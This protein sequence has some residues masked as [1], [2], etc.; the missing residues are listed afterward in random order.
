MATGRNPDGKLRTRLT[1]TAVALVSLALLAACEPTHFRDDFE[2]PDAPELGTVEG[3]TWENWSSHWTVSGNQ[4]RPGI[5][6]A[7]SV[8]PTDVAEGKL[9]VTAA[10]I[11]SEFW[12]VLRAVDSGNYWRFGRWQ[13]G[14]Y[15]LQQ[16]TGG[17]IGTPAVTTMA[18][19]MP[20]NGDRLACTYQYQHIA[21]SV[22]GQLV[23]GT[24]VASPAATGVGIASFDPGGTGSLRFDGFR[25]T[26]L[27]NIIDVQAT[28]TGPG[29][30]PTGGPIDWTVEVTNTGTIDRAEVGLSIDLPPGLVAPVVTPSQGSCSGYPVT[31]DLGPIAALGSATVAV[32]GTAPGSP[33][34]LSVTATAT[35]V[36]DGVPDNDSA[37]LTTI[38]MAPASIGDEVADQFN[39]VGA[40]LGQTD[41]GLEWTVAAGQFSTD[42]SRAVAAGPGTSWASVSTPMLFGTLDVT[43]AETGSGRFWALF[44]VVDSQNHYR[45]GPGPTG[46]YELQ[47]VVN[48]VAQPVTHYYVR[49]NVAAASGDQIRIV[50][51]PDD[52]ILVLVNDQHVID[53]GDLAFMTAFGYG[54]AGDPGA[55]F[56]S[57]RVRALLTAG[58]VATDSFNRADGGPGQLD[59]ALSY[60]WWYGWGFGILDQ[61][62]APNS[63]Y[64]GIAAVDTA[65]EL[66]NAKVRVDVKGQTTALVFRYVEDG[67]HYSFGQLVP[68]GPYSVSYSKPGHPSFTPPVTG[69]SSPVPADGDVI[70]VRQHLDGR[71]E[72]LVNGVPV[73]EFHDTAN[74]LRA[75]MYGVAA[76][77]ADAR[78]DDFEVTPH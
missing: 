68:D 35:T 28:M 60:P 63:P 1:R 14:P 67:S 61:K 59:G 32:S 5:G 23:A 11:S 8:V 37:S 10:T 52:S 44:G 3:G 16:V 39:R 7:L 13:G 40:D 69:L 38:V 6:Y 20:A 46:Y 75:T 66:A 25:L 22:S 78:F 33:A 30:V 9:Y 47:K 34:D 43:V 27:P 45:V 55:S 17:G 73:L 4:A 36:E 56:D 51:R 18:H 74:N 24:E 26:E 72:G 77:G 41:D 76:V 21:C 48:G 54:I 53:A 12:L 42:G 31:C 15:Q 64:Y 71:V 49:A 50:R 2:R 58:V 57:F 65:S 19:R 29:A 62:L 70:E